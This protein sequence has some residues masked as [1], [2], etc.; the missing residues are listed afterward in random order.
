M[1]RVRLLFTARD[2][3]AAGHVGAV[4]RRAF[5]RGDCD[6]VLAADGPARGAWIAGGWNVIAFEGGVVVDGS[7]PSAL[8]SA[9]RALVDDVRPDAIVT[10]LSGPE[11]GLDEALHQVSRVPV[12]AVQDFPGDVNRVL[13]RRPDNVFVADEE[14]ARLTRGRSSSRVIVSG[15]PKHARLADVDVAGEALAAL[16][17]VPA[18]VFAFGVYLQPLEHL[19]GYWTSMTNVLEAVTGMP[20]A[21]VVLAR[22]H[23]KAPDAASR[24]VAEAH[25]MG[26]P[27][28]DVS[29]W[30]LE[31][32][33]IRSDV[34]L[35]ATSTVSSDAI[36]LARLHGTT[37][38][39]VV[40]VLAPEVARD[41]WAYGNIDEIPI[42]SQGL[43]ERVGPDV[44]AIAAGI[45]RALDPKRRSRLAEVLP[46]IIPDARNAPDKILDVVFR[47]L[48]LAGSA[49]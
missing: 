29:T 35:T 18:E 6:V 2:P 41:T 11:A 21:R 36:V 4:A 24:L 10:G 22:A 45:S 49:R 23:P 8:L 20:G 44:T 30:P 32:A 46:A 47:D 39:A 13:Q 7:D 12:Y 40:H 43:A 42:V 16:A 26:L 28:L 48:A 34:L 3:G 37:P 14:A 15:A 25:A 31:R 17:R 1:G 38:P 5:Q 33:L 19:S 9:A 27:A